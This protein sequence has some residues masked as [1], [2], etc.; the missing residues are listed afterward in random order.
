MGS[1][2]FICGNALIDGREMGV[3]LF[4]PMEWDSERGNVIVDVGFEV[5][6][7]NME[8]WWIWEDGGR[9]GWC[10]CEWVLLCWFWTLGRGVV[11]WMDGWR[12]GLV[13]RIEG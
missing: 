6:E 13:L 5:L 2:N 11:V 8:L 12:S 4:S 10:W 3:A 7:W 1:G 9:D